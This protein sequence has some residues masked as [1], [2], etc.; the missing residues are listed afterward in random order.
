MAK[1]LPVSPL[2]P[3]KFPDL[4]IIGGVRFATVTAGGQM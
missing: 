4:P 2:A 1:A 3:A